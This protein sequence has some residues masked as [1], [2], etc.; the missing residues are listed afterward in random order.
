MSNNHSHRSGA[1][2]SLA[3]F[4]GAF[5]AIALWGEPL[6]ARLVLPAC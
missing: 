4:I 5:L 2:Y 6:T 1:Y 3:P